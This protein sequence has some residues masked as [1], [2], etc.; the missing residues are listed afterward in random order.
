[1]EKKKVYM[2]VDDLIYSM[3]YVFKNSKN[4]ISLFNLG[5]G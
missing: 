2:H 5:L 3:N 4:K 1:M